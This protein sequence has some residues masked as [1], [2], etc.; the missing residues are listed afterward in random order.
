MLIGLKKRGLDIDWL[1][2]CDDVIFLLK[3]SDFQFHSNLLQFNDNYR[4]FRVSPPAQFLARL[5]FDVIKG[6]SF[7]QHVR[8]DA[9]FGTQSLPGGH[10]QE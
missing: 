6:G 3:L 1:F 2:Y 4:F 5:H 8:R 10:A 7:Q 9:Q